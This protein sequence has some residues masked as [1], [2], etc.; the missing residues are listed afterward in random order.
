MKI[1]ILLV[2]HDKPSLL[3]KC[4]L[5]LLKYTNLDNFELWIL[6]N[7]ST[8]SNKK[9]ISA[10]TNKNRFIKV[11]SS[12]INQISLIQNELI[13]KIKSEI[14]IKIDDDIFVTEGWTDALL[15]VY[16]RNYKEIS[17]GS[18]IIP[19]NGFGWI[20]FLNIMDLKDEFAKKFPDVDL[21]QDCVESAVWYNQDVCEFLWNNCLNLDSVAERFIT[22]QNMNF[23]DLVCPHRYS[24]GAII[25][26]YNFWE[27]LG[28]WKIPNSFNR[29]LFIY[30][31]LNYL[32]T[33]IS[34]IRKRPKQERLNIFVKMLVGFHKSDLGLEE[35]HAYRYSVE[36][37]LKIY[38][39]TEGIV[40]HF[41][42]HPT[43]KH[44]MKKIYL[45]IR[46]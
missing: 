37:G 46:F 14:Y 34:K 40:Y 28:G 2:T 22:K 9:I 44:L 3:E 21:I 38:I 7:D 18:L 30:K 24:I 10:F 25:F 33:I 11:Y 36:K 42:F 12:S 39:T 6:D 23:K 27:S 15:N 32:I 41:A 29:K 31:R 20:P 45:D 13:K 4:L 8:I 19:I 5:R 16:N 17:F 26:S 35:E 43:E 1:P